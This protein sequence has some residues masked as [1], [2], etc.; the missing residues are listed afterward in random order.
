[1]NVVRSTDRFLRATIPSI[2]ADKITLIATVASAPIFSKSCIEM[3]APNW[4]AS[5][6]SNTSAWGGTGLRRS[7]SVWFSG[8][9]NANFWQRE[10]RV[11]Y[12]ERR[13]DNIVT[14]CF[15]REQE[16]VIVP[17]FIGSLWSNEHELSSLRLVRI[18]DDEP[19][20]ICPACN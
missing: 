15:T 8:I 14:L 16:S 20:G 19:I 3:P 9:F 5:T 7:T 1:M 4:M 2:S 12:K 10:L 13:K 17:L 6:A 11:D 18:S